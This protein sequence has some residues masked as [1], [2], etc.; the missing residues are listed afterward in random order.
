MLNKSEI[1]LIVD[2][3]RMVR[4]VIKKILYTLGYENVIEAEN[5]SECLKRYNE[6]ASEGKKI[7]AIFL[8]IVMPMI[9]GKEVL[10][11]IRLVDQETPVIMLTSVADEQMI[12]ECKAM[13]IL[14]YI[15]KPINSENGPDIIQGVIDKISS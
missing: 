9:T 1:I 3:M 8:D 13:G 11:E 5:G 10:Q 14:D 2:D 12:D 4:N 7:G 15:V 6:C